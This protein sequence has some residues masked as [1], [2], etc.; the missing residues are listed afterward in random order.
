MADAEALDEEME[1]EEDLMEYC[2]DGMGYLLKM[3]R[4]GRESPAACSF[5]LKCV[6]VPF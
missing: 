2:V 1:T 4:D 6:K 5:S 3:H